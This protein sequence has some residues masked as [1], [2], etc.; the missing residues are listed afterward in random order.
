[1][2]SSNSGVHLKDYK[3][4][5]CRFLIPKVLSLPPITQYGSGVDALPSNGWNGCHDRGFG[6]WVGIEAF[7]RLSAALTSHCIKRYQRCRSFGE[8]QHDLFPS[9]PI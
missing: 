2:I 3:V 4:E 9:T 6:H 5:A 8:Q 1:M 7:G